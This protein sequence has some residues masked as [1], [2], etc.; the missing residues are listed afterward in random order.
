MKKKI[1]ENL[2]SEESFRL[3]G[4]GFQAKKEE[5]MRANNPTL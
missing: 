1:T 4:S 5:T 3:A 2:M